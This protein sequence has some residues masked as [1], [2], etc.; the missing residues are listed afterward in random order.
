[1]RQALYRP[2]RVA[3]LVHAAAHRLLHAHLA[4]V[5]P[6]VAHL[7]LWSIVG[8][9]TGVRELPLHATLPV[10]RR[11]HSALVIT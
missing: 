10:H 3:V 11:G 2:L 7:P 4:L 5:A 8:W 1:M 6:R 9:P